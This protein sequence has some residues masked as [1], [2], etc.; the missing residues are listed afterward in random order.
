MCGFVGVIEPEG[1]SSHVVRE[2]AEVLSHRGPDDVG[3]LYFDPHTNEFVEPRS[4]D[5]RLRKYTFGMGFC[6]LSILD[7]RPMVISQCLPRT[8]V[9]PSL[10]TVRSITF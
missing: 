9:S 1:V 2:M 8:D 6:R 3:F 7:S 5:E 10:I 4:T